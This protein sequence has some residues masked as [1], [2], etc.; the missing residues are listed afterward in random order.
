MRRILPQDH[1]PLIRRGLARLAFDRFGQ[2]D[3][4]M[5]DRRIQG[6]FDITQAAGLSSARHSDFRRMFC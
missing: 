4:F 2:C 3:Q 6:I 1:G 5:A